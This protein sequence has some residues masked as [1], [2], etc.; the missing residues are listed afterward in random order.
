MTMLT[1][2]YVP[3]DYLGLIGSLAQ[4]LAVEYPTVLKG[5]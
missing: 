4:R 1:P 3:F 5:M 2:Q